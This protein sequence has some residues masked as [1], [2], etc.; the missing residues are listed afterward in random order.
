MVKTNKIKKS[1]PRLSLN[2]NVKFVKKAQTKDNKEIVVSKKTKAQKKIIAI[3]SQ[4][5]AKEM[6]AAL[7]NNTV[8]ADYL[9]RNVS[10]NVFEI[11]NMLTVPRTDEIISE[12]LNVQINSIR[13]TLNRLQNYGITNYY[14]AKNINGWLSF[15]WY[16][17][18]GKVSS[19]FSY[20]DSV[21]NK[22][23]IITQDCNDY[24]ICKK[25]GVE[26]TLIFTFDAAYEAQFKCALCKSSF[27]MIS[28]DEVTNILNK[29]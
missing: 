17:N 22:E 19:F 7:S 23:S 14:I 15:A 3:P 4:K 28:K 13:R 25:C 8:A 9:M 20:I 2:K 18:I 11:I 5:E 21:S 12:K 24:F 29:T 26:N 27:D 6:I 16:I 1:A 10:K